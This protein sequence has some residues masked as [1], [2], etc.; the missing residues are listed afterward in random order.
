MGKV[1]P[2]AIPNASPAVSVAEG[3]DT[4]PLPWFITSSSLELR[5]GLDPLTVRSSKQ[6][7]EY[8][9]RAEWPPFCWGDSTIHSAVCAGPV[10]VTVLV[11]AQFCVWSTSVMVHVD[12][13][14]HDLVMEAHMRSAFCRNSLIFCW[15]CCWGSSCHPGCLPLRPL[16]GDWLTKVQQIGRDN[17]VEV[18]VL[19]PNEPAD[20]VRDAAVVHEAVGSWQQGLLKQLGVDQGW[21]DAPGGE[22][23]TDKPDWDGYS[24]VVLL[25]AYDEQPDL[26]PHTEGRWGLRRKKAAG[27][28]PRAFKESEAFKAARESPGRYPTLLSGTEWCL[29][30][31]NGPTTFKA[32]A[33]VE[34]AAPFGLG[35]LTAIAQYASQRSVPWIMDY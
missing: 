14:L 30:L 9:G 1:G 18:R 22:Y 28:A 3:V 13:V 6:K 12:D 20:A 26:A 10:Y 16:A 21:D 33:S 34:K 29:L 31:S 35:M 32:P 25:A 27:T 7:V 8:G 4:A 2:S 17:N 15:V 5:W 19:R 24:A 23:V 11:Q